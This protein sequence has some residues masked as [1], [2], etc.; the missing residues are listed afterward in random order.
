LVENKERF[1]MKKILVIEDDSDVR[2]SIT[3][4]LQEEGFETFEAENGKAGVELAKKSFPDL[5][6]SDIHMPEMDGYGV[7]NE[8]QKFA[9]T[10]SIPFIFLSARTENSDIRAGM[11]IGAD[12]YLTKPYKAADLLN[13][14]NSRLNKKDRSDTR[15]NNIFKAI[16]MSLP[17]EFRTPLISIIGFSQIIK[18]DAHSLDPDEIMDM[19]STMYAS[20]YE[21]LNLIEKFLAYS[22][23]ETIA[24]DV[25]KIQLLRNSSIKYC[26]K[27]LVDTSHAISEKMGRIS[28]LN[29]HLQDTSIKI[30]EDH[31]NLLIKE[32]LENAFKFSPKGKPVK[33][34]TKMINNSYY[35]ELTDFGYGMSEEQIKDIGVLRQF[36]R[37]KK[38]QNG[39]GLGLAIVSKITEIYGLN[40]Q[41]E[42]KPQES[43]T[44][45]IFI[46]IL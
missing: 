17:H 7:L 3:E 40:F 29:L 31:F 12:D 16:S 25:N 14:I 33:I 43:T 20:G 32:L 36:D 28:D 27:A 5:I 30:S 10:S 46:P 18:E 26:E 42:S 22:A 23:L 8:L 19:A 11:D 21:L 39:T 9:G 44:I 38:C 24:G 6:I 15:L 35:I 45:K 34:R 4:L 13:A 37:N 2:G 1:T 41:I